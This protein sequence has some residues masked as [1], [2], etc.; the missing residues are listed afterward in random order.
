MLE[1]T[2]KSRRKKK[3]KQHKDIIL[4]T[5][6]N[7]LKRLIKDKSIILD[8]R[9]G[10]DS[11]NLNLQNSSGTHKTECNHINEQDLFLQAMADV[12]PIP[13][14]SNI[15]ELTNGRQSQIDG[16]VALEPGAVISGPC[17]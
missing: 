5:P 3:K 13:G 6:F 16:Q 7:D 11:T 10:L 14:K 1:F 4:D 15:T 2:M 9:K 8:D 12:A 17:D